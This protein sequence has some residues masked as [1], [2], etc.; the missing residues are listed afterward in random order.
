MKPIGLIFLFASPLP[1]LLIFSQYGEQANFGA[2][3]SQ[4]LGML[5]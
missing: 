2:L 5:A 4:Y 3:V 1:P